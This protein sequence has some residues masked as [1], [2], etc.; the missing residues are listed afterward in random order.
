MGLESVVI[1]D[2]VE[3]IYSGA[4]RENPNLKSIEIKGN[5]TTAYI[6]SFPDNFNIPKYPKPGT[7]YPNWA[8]VG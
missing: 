4:F 1:P 5:K 2:S 3:Y 6:N 8:L 7:Y